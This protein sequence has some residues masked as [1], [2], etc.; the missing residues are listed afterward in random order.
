MR[1][2]ELARATHRALRKRG[3][4]VG[5]DEQEV[6]QGMAVLRRGDFPALHTL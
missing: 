4:A 6:Q 5:V 2:G 1:I 3:P